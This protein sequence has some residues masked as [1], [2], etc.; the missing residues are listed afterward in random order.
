[1]TPQLPH[2]WCLFLSCQ[3]QKKTWKRGSCEVIKVILFFVTTLVFSCQV[4]LC[5][6]FSKVQWHST[7]LILLFSPLKVKNLFQYISVSDLDLPSFLGQFIFYNVIFLFIVS[8]K[9]NSLYQIRSKMLHGTKVI[10]LVEKK[11]E[12]GG[13][14]GI[15]THGLHVTS[16]KC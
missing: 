15:W 4:S 10:I 3:Q 14:A 8:A 6:Y 2:F 11:I 13:L 9:M 12:R 5:C 7:Y 16:R 1:M